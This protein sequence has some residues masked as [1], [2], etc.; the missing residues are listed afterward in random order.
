MGVRWANFVVLTR[1]SESGENT[2]LIKVA[3]SI[4]GEDF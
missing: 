4:V 3:G 1:L 2:Y